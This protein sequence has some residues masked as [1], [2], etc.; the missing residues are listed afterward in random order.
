[1]FLCIPLFVLGLLM[2]CVFNIMYRLMTWV[3]ETKVRVE[4]VP[5]VVFSSVDRKKSGSTKEISHYSGSYNTQRYVKIR[6]DR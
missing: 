1:M 5:Y 2:L 6:W 3:D 4:V